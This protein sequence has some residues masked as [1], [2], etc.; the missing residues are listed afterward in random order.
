MDCDIDYVPDPNHD[1]E[2]DLLDFCIETLEAGID[3]DESPANDIEFGDE[4]FEV[5]H[6]L[7]IENVG[8]IV[9]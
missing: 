6:K 9:H 7:L 3:R 4:A 2:A 1:W 8:P 5:C